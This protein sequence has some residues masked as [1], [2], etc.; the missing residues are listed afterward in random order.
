MQGDVG[1]G[2]DIGLIDPT[3]RVLASCSIADFTT[4]SPVKGGILSL[5]MLIYGMPFLQKFDVHQGYT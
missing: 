5:A 4:I 3:E 1:Q 2:F